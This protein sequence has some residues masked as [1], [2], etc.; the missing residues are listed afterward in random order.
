V[1]K[2]LALACAALFLCY[3]PAALYVKQT[4]VD[5]GLAGLKPLHI[6]RSAIKGVYASPLWMPID[7][8][9]ATVYQHGSPIVQTHRVVDH[10]NRSYIVGGQRWKVIEFKL[11][12]EPEGSGYFGRPSC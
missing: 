12:Y 1:P 10:P 9:H 6:Y 3:L 4:H 11:P 2:R 7:C 8:Q 5:I